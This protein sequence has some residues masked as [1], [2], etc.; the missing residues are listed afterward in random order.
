MSF[1]INVILQ[2]ALGINGGGGRLL[3]GAANQPSWAVADRK[4]VFMWR[5]GHGNV[6]RESPHVHVLD[7]VVTCTS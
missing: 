6:K 5:E 2:G 1:V 7:Y 4:Y 3:L